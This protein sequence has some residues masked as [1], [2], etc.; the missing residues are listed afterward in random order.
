MAARRA[1][2][3]GAIFICGCAKILGFSDGGA[4]RPIPA[5]P[6]GEAGLTALFSDVLEAA[7]HDD[8]QRVHD[9]L[10]STIL[11]DEELQSLFGADAA[12]LRDRYHALM[13]TLVNRG[14]VELVA[15]IYERKYDAIEAWRVD[16]S[17]KEASDA[18]RAVAHALRRP[19][20][21]YAARIKRQ[22]D[23][24][25]LRYDFFVYLE[26]HWRT[27]NQLGAALAPNPSKGHDGGR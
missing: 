21:V 3:M 13:E 23:T 16:P 12:R 9:L 1:L 8:R 4:A 15:Q 19:L 18:D 6:D 20:P 10:A 17:A 11:T 26:G 2:A 22:G 7:R 14:S 5:Y 27:G 24:R 25:G